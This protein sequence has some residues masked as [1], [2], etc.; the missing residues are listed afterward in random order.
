MASDTYLGFVSHQTTN[1]ITVFDPNSNAVI[2]TFSTD[3]SPRSI[4]INPG[5]TL[6]YVPCVSSKTVD[7]Y[8]AGDYTKIAT[9]TFPTGVYSVGTNAAGNKLYVADTT[10]HVY[11][12]DTASNTIT[13]TITLTAS[14]YGQMYRYNDKLYITKGNANKVAVVDTIT[15]A[16]STY[17]T[18]ADTP[19]GVVGNTN[20]GKIY[21]TGEYNTGGGAWGTTVSVINPTT[22]TVT[23]TINLG[24][25]GPMGPSIKSDGTRLYVPCSASGVLKVIDTSSDT[26]IATVNVGSSSR[27]SAVEINNQYVYVSNYDNNNITVIST[28]TNTVTGNINVS[29]ANPDYMGIWKIGAEDPNPTPMQVTFTVT[30]RGIIFHEDVNVSV[31]DALTN[32]FKS[33]DT[34]DSAGNVIFWLIPGKRYTVNVTGSSIQ[35]MAE[36]IQVQPSKDQYS[37]YVSPSTG[38][39][40]PFNWFNTNGTADT[41]SADLSKSINVQA[42]WGDDWF[43]AN[44]TDLSSTTTNINFTLYTRNASAQ[45]WDLISSKNVAAANGTGN[46]TISAAGTYRINVT[47]TTP[48]WNNGYVYRQVDHTFDGDYSFNMGWPSWAALY[49]PIFLILCAALMGTRRYE[50]ATGVF[51]V[52]LLW[53]LSLIGW[54]SWYG[55]I[56]SAVL[57]VLIL[58]YAV[59]KWRTENRV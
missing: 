27:G 53:V 54:I 14:G 47:G 33:S 37:I 11:V 30:T 12:V 7:V 31:Y 45:K 49:V 39:W 3:T 44:Y 50:L 57:T 46:F 24:A 40:D 43:A 23:G 29:F 18:V 19:R 34:T 16:V 51:V 1:T 56:V 42:G 26:V 21:V 58:V 52:V 6:I 59:A 28:S 36:D 20:L 17:I 25:N 8:Q 55:I 2:T 35:A 13:K 5:G 9:I 32:E 41:G 4:I 48:M 38:W 10:T 22:D 15:D